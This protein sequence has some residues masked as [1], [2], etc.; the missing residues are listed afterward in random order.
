M[1]N[2]MVEL[3]LPGANVVS[4]TEDTLTAELTDGRTV[5][6]PL[7]WYP[8]LLHATP[9]ERDNWELFADARHIHWPDLDEDI[10]IEGLLAGRSSREGTESF[11]RWSEAKRA[12][13]P[14]TLDAL[15]R[16]DDG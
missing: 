1:A 15:R 12:G 14:I 6:V 16:F 4:A 3:L 2:S 8:R 11:R 13:R 9:K 7:A 10:S 5:S